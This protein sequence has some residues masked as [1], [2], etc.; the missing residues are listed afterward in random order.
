MKSY[1]LLLGAFL[2]VGSVAAQNSS[3]IQDEPIRAA[4]LIDGLFFAEHPEPLPAGPLS[5]GVV[6]DSLGREVSVVA[7]PEGT[8]LSAE[9]VAL[10]VPVERVFCGEA[11]LQAAR[12]ARLFSVT[13]MPPAPLLCGVGDSLPAFSETDDTGR[14]WSN[15]DLMG[16]SVVLNFWHTGC[17]PCIGEMPELNR[18]MDAC[19]DALFL[20]VTWNTAEQIRPIVERQGFDFHHLVAARGLWDALGVRQTPVTMIVDCKGI[21]RCI[22]IGTS[23]LQRRR[24]LN[25]L[26]DV[27]TENE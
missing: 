13:T 21:I 2:W 7:F 4:L 24:L 10:A 18:W 9:A 14:Q 6:R 22:E 1:V 19:P 3:N 8:H 25:C 16:H 11:L 26:K 23:V 12:T 17:K 5:L 15:R 27:E 20:S